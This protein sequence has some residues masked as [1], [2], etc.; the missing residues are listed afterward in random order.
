MKI[1]ENWLREWINP[2]LT[3][4]NLVA[5]LSMAGLEVE[6]CEKV[7]DDAVIDIDLTPNRGD[8]LSVFGVAREVAALNDMEMKTHII[9]QITPTIQDIIPVEVAAPDFCPRY[10]G[11]VIRGINKHA[12]T[13]IWMAEKLE[14]SGI[15]LIH[16]IVDILNYIM[17]EQGQ[18]MHAFDLNKID[19]LQVRMANAGEKIKLLNDQEVSL[20][21]NTLV[22]A[23]QT[24]AEAIAGIMGGADSG[25]QAD[26][27]DIFLESALF[28]SERMVGLARQYGLHTDSSYRFERGVAS[29]LQIEAMESAT[30]HI[31]EITGGQAGPL[32]VVENGH[33]PKVHEIK[34][35]FTKLYGILG[36]TLDT[37]KVGSILQRFGCKI[38]AQDNDSLTVLPNPYRLD[39]N[40]EIDLIEEVIRAHGYDNV[41]LNMPVLHSEFL[42]HSETNVDQKRIKQI[43]VDMGFQEIVSYSFVDSEI[44]KQLFEQPALPLLNPIAANMNEMRL[45][46]WPGLLSTLK[47]NQHRQ[48]KR[49]K[50]FEMGLC[51]TP[52]ENQNT[53]AQEK[54]VGGLLAGMRYP[55]NWTGKNE[56]FDFFDAKQS[57]ETIWQTLG[58]T[59]PLK[60]KHEVHHTFHPGQSAAIYWQN[61]AVGWVGCLHPQLVQ[62]LDLDG[63]VYLFEVKADLLATKPLTRY[64]RISKFPEIRR[65]IAVL[66]DER[67]LTEQLLSAIMQNKPDWMKDVIVFDVYSGKGIDSGRKSVA[68]GLILQHASRTLVDEEV[69]KLI[70]DV[71]SRLQKEFGAQLRE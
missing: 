19:G 31:L 43:L 60:F 44:Q 35:R 9:P 57:V 34:L 7:D 68:L 56:P 6:N 27:Q 54:R 13:P 24:R 65:D 29:Q 50:C 47:Y 66:V 18:P 30:K 42:P 8:C 15:R 33:I 4:E 48:Q 3:T 28:V 61:K 38:T 16:P 14:K 10:V 12:A 55:E 37:Q 62:A 32:I 70:Q 36:T 52:S 20:L 23:S 26:T 5:Q 17:I 59:E 53:L 46:I 40:S 71:I 67:L 64:E 45:S 69:D 11:R 25:V 21:P 39:L 49:L 58:N 63:P 22:I 51:F 41:P 1:S 2:S